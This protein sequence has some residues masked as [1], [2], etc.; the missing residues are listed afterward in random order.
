MIKSV[1]NL[2]IILLMLMPMVTLS[3]VDSADLLFREGSARFERGD[4]TGA[5]ERY[6]NFVRR[7]PQSG[8]YPDA[9]YRL[10]ISSIK[11]GEY[12]EGIELLKRLEARYPG[13]RFR[14]SFWLGI[15]HEALGDLE[16]ALS[17]WNSYITGEDTA[18]RR[19]ALV[20]AAYAYA[21]KD[22]PG[23]AEKLLL[24]LEEYD[25]KF[26]I[27]KGGLV[28]LAELY[29]R[30]G[31]FSR[32][33][34]LGERFS[35]VP[36]GSLPPA[37]LLTLG[38]AHRQ[39]E[40]SALAEELFR[41]VI[42][43]GPQ[44]LRASAYGRLFSLY[45]SSG[46]LW[47][48]EN[49]V[50]DA[51]NRLAGDREALA[52]FWFRAGAVLASRGSS[53]DGISYLKRAWDI[54]NHTDP[55]GTLPIFYA[56]ALMSINEAEAAVEILET[57]LKEGIGDSGRIRY[58]LA[59]GYSR[60][61][62]WPAVKE[63][64]GSGDRPL[65]APVSLLLAQAHLRLKEYPEGLSVA[66]AALE[67]M[68]PREWQRGLLKLSWQLQAAAGEY[69]EA[70]KT[71]AQYKRLS[72]EADDAGDPQYLR[73]LFNAGLYNQVVRRVT[74]DAESWEVRLLRGMALIG[75]EEYGEARDTLALLA[76]RDMP[77]EYR[78]FRDYYL[79][80]SF[81][82][83]GDYPRALRNFRTFRS[84]YPDSSLASDA[85]WYGGWSAFSLKDYASAAE[86]FGACDPSGPRGQ[87]ALM[88]RARALAAAGRR[89]EAILLAESYLNEYARR[90]GDEALYLVFE[91]H[92]ESANLDGSSKALSHLRQEYPES[93]WTSR[94]LYR[95]ARKNLEEGNYRSA[96]DGFDTYRR[97]FPSGE[98]SEESF[99]YRGEASAA[100]GETRLALLLWE[101]LVREYPDSPLR[102]R[103]LSLRGETLVELG[104]YKEALDIYALLLREYP[105]Q[106]ERLGIR[107]EVS[108]LESLLVS[109]GSEYRRLLAEADSAGGTDSREGRA[110][111]IRAIQSAIAEGRAED[112]ND[113]G[114][115]VR[116]LLNK[117]PENKQEQGRVFF[118]AGEYAFRRNEYAE[119]ASRYLRAA[120]T[121]PGDPDFTAQAL[122]RSAQMSLYAGDRN[123]YNEVL[124]RLRRNF[125][126]SPWLESAESLGEKR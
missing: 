82:R 4:Y 1:T 36:R 92:L 44:D 103:A 51:E 88:A 125:S 15:A 65:D 32:I 62:D 46:R 123:A 29:R 17:A 18:Y 84:E 67:T 3:A 34:E 14:T 112:F 35:A 25:G 30:A 69:G 10:G 54:R 126:G 98:Y 26:F 33:V 43:A 9:L 110:L 60:L 2:C 120:L 117:L 94:A 48:M 75:I 45:E 93:P 107:E 121:M 53:T 12:E 8:K 89:G 115:L 13:G 73:L 5:A 101:R 39:Q 96:A 23:A 50:L 114:R 100:M 64:L 40:D 66:S 124:T 118:V 68:P 80:W 95:L 59:V 19:E 41:S 122:Y 11:I 47:E 6:R 42:E 108:R 27:D 52:A 87:E 78:Q 58:R 7:Y 99:F 76:P 28:L 86:L 70:V 21:E 77:S 116:Q 24:I 91:I 113:A 63:L 72:G 119:A 55:P 56:Q 102:P 83:L 61:D 49:L 105:A 38:E 37:F 90:G 20:A 71:Y 111:L 79:A 31:S 57:A 97:L 85:A 74:A 22:T 106:A 104:E 109:P 81:Y 16:N